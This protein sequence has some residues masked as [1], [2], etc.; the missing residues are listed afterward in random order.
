MIK[1]ILN[2]LKAIAC[3]TPIALAIGCTSL[4]N[5]LENHLQLFNPSDP[6]PLLESEEGYSEELGN[7]R[8]FIEGKKGDKNKSK[9]TA[10]ARTDLLGRYL[11]QNWDRKGENPLVVLKRFD[12]GDYF[13]TEREFFDMMGYLKGKESGL[14]Y[15]FYLRCG[16][17]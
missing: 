2:G 12:N 17:I 9:E 5:K 16:K 4:S 3:I 13:I 14:L 11:L 8:Y 1:N 15:D 6:F 7:T 10:M